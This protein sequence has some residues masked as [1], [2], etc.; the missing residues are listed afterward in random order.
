MTAFFPLAGPM[1]ALLLAGCAMPEA[2]SPYIDPISELVERREQREI[3]ATTP[4]PPHPA[5]IAYHGGGLRERHVAD[6]RRLHAIGSRVLAANAPLCGGR[7]TADIGLAVH[8]LRP[9][10]ARW[11]QSL[12]PGSETVVLLQPDGPAAA[13]G[14]RPDDVVLEI[15]D[16]GRV[17]ALRGGA[18]VEIAATPRPRCDFGIE[19][20]DE[21]EPTAHADGRSVTMSRAMLAFAD[22][23]E[24]AL[25][26]GHE[27]AHNALG[28][29]DKRRE[30]AETGT[31]IGRIMSVIAGADVTERFTRRGRIA[32][33]RAFEREADYVGLYMAARAGF[34]VSGTA[35]LWRRMAHL[36]PAT[37]SEAGTHPTTADRYLAIEAAIAEIA[38]KRARGRELLPDTW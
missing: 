25:V 28:H 18:E 30:N 12:E 27:L 3:V 8:D 22:D 31:V 36:S 2:R 35:A 9:W 21:G 10:A 6:L 11:E 29:L 37:I 1:L 16:S 24:V 7:V 17:R 33:T 15:A 38:A 19:L 32:F 13:A 4:A 26:F 34:D 23:S 14:L 20:S 5:A